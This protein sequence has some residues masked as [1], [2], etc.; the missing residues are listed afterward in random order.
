MGKRTGRRAMRS[1]SARI[2]EEPRS[3]DSESEE[4]RGFLEEGLHSEVLP[5]GEWRSQND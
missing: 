4:E 5:L 3:L 1:C 2:N